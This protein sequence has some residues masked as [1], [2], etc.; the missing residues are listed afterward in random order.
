MEISTGKIL[1][2]NLLQSATAYNT[3]PNIHRVYKTLGILA[4]SRKL[5]M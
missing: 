5:A 1:E 4:L 3:R 2:E